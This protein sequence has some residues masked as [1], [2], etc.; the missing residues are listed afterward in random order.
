[1]Q[2]DSDHSQNGTSCVF[3]GAD[4]AIE[5]GTA[6]ITS[7]AVSP[8]IDVSGMNSPAIRFWY[9]YTNDQGVFGGTAPFKLSAASN[10]GTSYKPINTSAGTT[11]TTKGW[12]PFVFKVKD[13]L[14]NAV[15]TVKIRAV[16]SGTI[17]KQTYPDQQP[18]QSGHI[19]EAGLDD[20][21]VLDPPA[22]G[23]A[24]VTT[25]E[26]TS[27]NPNPATPGKPITMA[28]SK[29]VDGS[30]AYQLYN[31]LGALVASGTSE[32]FASQSIITLPQSIAS[33]M[34]QIILNSGNSML[35]YHFMIVSK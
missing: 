16:T 29:I 11:I 18:P 2:Q 23:V 22:L 34:Y 28:S 15:N 1:I 24:D 5:T 26:A 31:G 7:T 14:G 30:I 25:I 10:G 27:I 17:P 19:I 9:Y 21:E 6:S 4:D 13:V 8:A 20:I 12:K 33:G 32:G 35:Y 3:T